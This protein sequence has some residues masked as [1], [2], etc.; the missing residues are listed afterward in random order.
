M[1]YAG[2]S[3][4]SQSSKTIIAQLNVSDIPF[5]TQDAMLQGLQTAIQTLSSSLERYVQLVTN[6]SI[7]EER[8]EVYLDKID[9]MEA[10]LA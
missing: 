9:S 7:A 8:R 4:L 1:V 3:T 10:E 5:A 6:S 2:P